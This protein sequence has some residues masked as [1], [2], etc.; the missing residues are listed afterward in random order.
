M[1]PRAATTLK[2]HLMNLKTATV[3]QQEVERAFVPKE[4]KVTTWSKLKP[5][6]SELLSRPI[7]ALEEL[8]Q[9]IKDKSELDAVVSEAFSWRYIKITVNSTDERA[10]ALYQYAVQELAPKISSFEHALN[11]KLV[12]NPFSSQ[13]NPQEYGIHMR[14]IR[15][16]VNLFQEENIPLATD[17]Q[18]KSKEYVK[19]FSEMTIGVDGKQMTLQKASSLLEETDRDYREGVYHKIHQRI[20]QDTE[21]LDELFDKLLRMRHQIALNSGFDNF[22]DF[23]FQALDRFDY[24]VEDCCDFHESIKSE[25]VPLIDDL[26]RYRKESLKLDKL[27]PWD[28]FV[29]PIGDTPLR[30]FETIEELVDKVIF[31]LNQIHPEFGKTIS[32]LKKMGHLDLETRPAKRP[33]AYNMPLHLTGMPFIFMNAT[34]S[35]SDMRTLMHE[36]GHAVHSCLTKHYKLKSAKRVPSEVAELAAMSMELLT[37]EHWSVFFPDEEKLRRAK[38]A[39]LE[40]VLKVLPWIATIDKFQHWIYTNPG[41]SREGRVHN[42][43][44]IMQEFNSSIIDH[45]GLENYSA[46][47]WHKQLHI[48][49]VPFYYIEYGMAQL[50]AIALWKQYRENPGQAV[51]NYLSALKLGYTKNI[52]EIYQTAGIEFNFSRDYVSQLGAFVKSELDALI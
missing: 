45:T 22:R 33:G 40:Y 12:E 41:H 34:T 25:I 10:E 23:K 51:E 36:A 38:I 24:T 1:P 44:A 4:F 11:Q 47:L 7:G 9:W 46:H 27:R 49:E 6:Y 30:P 14:S 26:N 31:C 50:G 19:I 16:A 48:F 2:K 35:L 13:L 5:Y 20:L 39:Q 21:Q 15:N 3:L 43:T 52:R 8:E 28:L 18:M 42:W 37:M 29:D 32:T 17:I